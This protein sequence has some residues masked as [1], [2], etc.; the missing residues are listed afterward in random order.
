MKIVTLLPS[1]TEIVCALGLADALVGVSHDCDYPPEILDRQVLSET[2]VTGQM[3][4]GEIDSTI[5]Q[6]VH[7]GK[8]VYHL[9]AVALAALA[10]DLILTQELCRVCAPSFGEVRQAARVLE[11]R[12]KI[13]SLEPHSLGDILET[14]LEVGRL[15]GAEA[16]A[17]ILVAGLRARIERVRA[18]PA[19]WPRPRVACVEWLDPIFVAG[20][21]VPQMVDLAGG[22]DGL[23]RQG[24]DSYVIEWDTLRAYAPEA[25]VVM[26]C[27]FDIARTRAEIYLLTARPGWQDLPAV[28]AGR[29]FLTDASA[30]FNRPGPR[31]VRGLEILAQLV[32]AGP[33]PLDVEGA[34]RP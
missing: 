25:V 26:P 11:G 29:V 6:Q 17:E 21:W 28:R 23:G 12:T 30:Y 14:I 7:T 8:S 20:H 5:R 32:R 27:G 4:S 1:A 13:V 3:P 33:G 16:A 2:I 9:D 19:P 31:I 34:E 24:K 22:V 15:T 10:P 18:L